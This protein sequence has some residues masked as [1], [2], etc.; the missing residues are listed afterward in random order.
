MGPHVKQLCVA[1][2]NKTNDYKAVMK[3]DSKTKAPYTLIIPLATS[4]VR[5]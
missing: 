1:H 3:T 4:E 2:N 5:I